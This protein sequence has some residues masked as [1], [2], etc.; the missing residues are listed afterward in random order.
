MKISRILGAAAIVL[1]VCVSAK[2][3][4]QDKRI[5][6]FS[7]DD[8][9]NNMIIMDGMEDLA[10]LPDMEMAMDNPFEFGGDMLEMG[11]PGRG[12]LADELNLSKDQ[13]D[14]IKKIRN[15]ARK[16]NIPIKG[17]IELKRIELKEL[18]DTDSPDKE[19][20]AAKLKEIEALKTQSAIIRVNG[21]IDFKNI[22]TKDQRE[23][24]EKMRMG[25][26]GMG[27]RKMMM[28]HFMNK[29]DGPMDK[30]RESMKKDK[31]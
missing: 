27:G 25:H 14:K 7:K 8:D 17:D 3:F 23:K 28:R 24:L 16:Q 5:E 10:S 13:M 9:D 26:R 19:K 4:A 15:T 29:D 11:M 30:D 22:L 18:M 21:M 1:V 20:I 12:M 2:A 31:D 6:I